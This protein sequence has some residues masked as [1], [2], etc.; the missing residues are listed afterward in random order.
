[1][2]DQQ[3]DPKPQDPREYW[4]DFPE[5]PFSDTFK[6]TDG[7]GFEHMTTIRG[8]SFQT[9]Y[10]TIAKAEAFILESGAKPIGKPAA[11][12]AAAQQPAASQANATG[13]TLAIKKM[14]VVQEVKDGKPRVKVSLFCDGHQ[15]ADLV[16]YCNDAKEAAAY[17]AMVTG[18]D[19]AQAGEYSVD[20]LADYR[21]SDKTNSKGNPY[22]NLVAVRPVN[23]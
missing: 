19:F 11:A 14:A 10:T 13:T 15:Y 2:T 5:A 8:W 23:S 3:Q 12:P 4:H 21:L 9:M 18:A 1:M 20:F 17:F 22:K 6:W 7:N 16:K